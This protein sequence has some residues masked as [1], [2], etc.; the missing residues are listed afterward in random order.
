MSVLNEDGLVYRVG[1]G[2]GRK[3]HKQQSERVLKHLSSYWT[4]R[5]CRVET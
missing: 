1:A 2:G 3:S 4:T 5:V